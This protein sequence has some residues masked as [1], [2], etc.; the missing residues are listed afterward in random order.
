MSA[1]A[2]AAKAVLILKDAKSETEAWRVT[3]RDE[4][5][6]EGRIETDRRNADAEGLGRGV[7]AEK[8]TDCESGG[9]T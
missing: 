3:F 7:E 1:R 2:S 9:R 5:L 8:T 6:V 4:R